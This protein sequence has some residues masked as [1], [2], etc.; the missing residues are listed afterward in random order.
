MY[1]ISYKYKRLLLLLFKLVIVI[2]ALYFI[3]EKLVYNQALSFSQFQNQFSIIF[4]KNIWYLIFILLLTD[5]NWLL[6]I[7]KWKILVSVEKKI[8][9]LEAFEQCLGSLTASIITP[10]RI[11]EYGVKAL[12]FEKKIRKK[13][14]LLNLIGNLSQLLATLTFGIL[15]F[16]IIWNSFEFEIP[17]LNIQNIFIGSSILIIL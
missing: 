8:T 12:Y 11:G 7:Y 16:I 4:T 3:Y 6:E 14:V 9:Y 15:G 2:A 17:E 10:N 1:N 13:I 5:A